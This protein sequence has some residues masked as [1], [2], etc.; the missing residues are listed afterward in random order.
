ML[1]SSSHLTPVLA[2][3]TVHLI[4]FVTGDPG[5]R[6][7]SCRGS[8]NDPATFSNKAT[9]D[10]GLTLAASLYRYR[11][12]GARRIPPTWRSR[13]AAGGSVAVVMSTVVVFATGCA[14]HSTNQDFP[15]GLPLRPVGQIALPGDNSRFGGAS[16]DVQ[17]GLLFISHIAENQL[18]EVD[19]NAQGVVRTIP[20]IAAVHGV[21]AVGALG[22]VYANA[23]RDNQVVAIDEITGQEL[24]R[25][26][27]G[28]YPDGLAYDSRR[29]TVWTSNRKAGTETV[30][31]A[32]T[33]QPRGVVDL[34]G[35]VGD[36]AYDSPSDRMLVA[37]QGRN[38][39]AVIDPA[40]MTVAA[41][42][43]LPECDY[44]HGL[45]IGEQDRLV[46]VGCAY[47]A[48]VVI[49]DETNWNIVGTYPVG[50]G[51]DTLAYDA[52]ARRLYVAA[53]SGILAVLILH[54]HNVPVIRSDLLADGAHVVSVDPNTHRT[55]YPVHGGPEGPVLLEREAT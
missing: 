31:D 53:E 4:A 14:N 41:R 19:I 26:P 43:A 40:A 16:L 12:V 11:L 24:G 37:L 21:L 3:L 36:V 22:R 6:R 28:A 46:F 52:A 30:V 48:S 32:V 23:T 44:P 10:T 17:R 1:T 38:E 55:Y 51:P 45:S 8:A 29:R 54:D 5:P 47:N 35:E 9:T 20:N 18:I 13:C 7:L 42:V 33:L 25:A 2:T 34:G 15:P 49:V 27:T 50:Q 39:L